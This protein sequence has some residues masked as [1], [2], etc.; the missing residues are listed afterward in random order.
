[1]GWLNAGKNQIWLRDGRRLFPFKKCKS[2]DQQRRRRMGVP[3]R[4]QGVSTGMLKVCSL[5][6][7]KLRALKG[8]CWE[9]MERQHDGQGLVVRHRSH[10]LIFVKAAQQVWMRILGQ[11]LWV[12]P[13]PGESWNRILQC[14]TLLNDL[15]LKI[16][17][18]T[19]EMISFFWG[20]SLI[21]YPPMD[22]ISPKDKAAE[23]T[24]PLFLVQSPSSPGVR[25]V[26]LRMYCLLWQ[27]PPSHT[28]TRARAHAHSAP[29]PPHTPQKNF[30]KL[31]RLVCTC[32][33]SAILWLCK[34]EV[35]P[36]SRSFSR[37]PY[38]WSHVKLLQTLWCRILLRLYSITITTAWQLTC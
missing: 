4:I 18:W 25:L 10:T 13:F 30:H 19:S 1:M 16:S 34:S 24:W 7:V 23:E 31:G 28:R 17:L 6:K 14:L 5:C 2:F 8:K 15:L 22:C 9:V 29:H 26:G 12:R 20:N 38:S 32:D 35:S 33:V 3:G 37:T 36:S 21:T 27:P 11:V